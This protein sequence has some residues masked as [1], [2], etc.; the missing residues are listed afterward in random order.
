MVDAKP[1][2]N[3]DYMSGGGGNGGGGDL[4]A[5]S[6]PYDYGYNGG[7]GDLS[8][9]SIPYD[10]GYNGG[11]GGGK[12]GGGG[13]IAYKI[14]IDYDYNGGGGN[15]LI[16]YDYGYNGGGGDSFASISSIPYDYGYN[17][18]GGDSFA[19]I[20]SIPYDYG[21]N[22]G[23]G[24]QPQHTDTVTTTIMPSSGNPG[25]HT[26]TVTT[27]ITPSSGYPGEHTGTVTIETMSPASPQQQNVGI[28]AENAASSEPVTDRDV[29][30]ALYNKL[31]DDYDVRVR[32]IQNQSK[33]IYV[34]T[35]FVPLSIIEFDT[36]EQTFAILGYFRV[37]W[38]DQT[39]T[40]RPK[41]WNYINTV[42]VATNVLWKPNIIIHK[43]VDGRGEI[44]ASE[45]DI[46]VINWNGNVQ[47]VPEGIYTIV[48]DVN[49]Q[50]FPFDVQTCVLTYY[51]ADESTASV[52]L[53]HYLTVDMSEYSENA[54][55]VVTSVT[56][57]RVVRNNNYY[58]DIEFRLQRRA[59]FA[60]FT[61]IAPLMALAFL[62]ISV[63]LVPVDSGEKG[64]FAITIFLSYGV[65]MT[66]ISDTLPNN[67]AQT[68]TFVLLLETLLCLSVLSVVYTVVQAK[69]A[70]T[71]GRKPCP[72]QCLRTLKKHNQVL[73]I[74]HCIEH[75]GHASNDNIIYTWGMFLK[76]LDLVLFFVFFVVVSIM[77]GIFFAVLLRHVGVVD[78][79]AD[80]EPQPTTRVFP[81]PTT[82]SG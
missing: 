12:G 14:P 49:I 8:A 36:T 15:F 3:N 68:S 4:T 82:A 30:K 47:W 79:Y 67:S 76:Q 60:L 33:P 29:V 80:M 46:L 58:I 55:W 34:N 43:A 66:I 19:S 35:K 65:F 75:G 51:V 9:K 2:N 81:I 56:R 23:G 69:L 11:G 71:I 53:D 7:G 25:E 26:D 37:R 21:Y 40:W 6:I 22:G 32:P 62:N 41:Y 54:E 44:G 20:S 59:N 72:I 10:Y 63:F 77:I 61:L 24:D 50:Y 38:I 70:L 52:T 5:K 17:G 27:T 42:K 39:M 74:D 16:P 13:V 45:T 48:C 57:Q 1:P 31:L 73:P 18:G 78:S 64:S 28:A